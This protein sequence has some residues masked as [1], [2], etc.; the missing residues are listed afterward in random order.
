MVKEV[1][2]LSNHVSKKHNQSGVVEE[3]FPGLDKKKI[4]LTEIRK[5]GEDT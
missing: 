5:C 2:L 4:V 3:V 1:I